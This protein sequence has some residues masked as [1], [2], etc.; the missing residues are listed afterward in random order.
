[1]HTKILSLFAVLV[2]IIAAN[3]SF[4]QAPLRSGTNHLACVNYNDGPTSSD[5]TLIV[6]LDIDGNIV[7][8][9][10]APVTYALLRTDSNALGDSLGMEWVKSEF[11][12]SGWEKG[13]SGVGFAD[14]DD[15][16][17]VNRNNPAGQADA[18]AIYTRY[19]FNL[20]SASSAKSVI[21][22][23]DYDDAY[24]CWL[25]GVE[26]ARSAG[27]TGKDLKWNTSGVG[28]HEATDL[29]KGAP[30]SA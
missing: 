25:N 8:N 18:I 9:E 28:N 21:L 7:V 17:E 13:V 11:D 15:N 22:R 23:A 26:A 20:A 19:R 10:G 1:M 3:F 5:M 16:T 2:L 14:G 4:A 27:L 12:D 24:A 29:A 30:N 6:Q